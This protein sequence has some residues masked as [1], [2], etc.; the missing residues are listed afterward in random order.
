MCCWSCFFCISLGAALDG[1]ALDHHLNYV[2]NEAVIALGGRV[3]RLFQIGLNPK[4]QHGG[5]ACAYVFISTTFVLSLY[6]KVLQR[7]KTFELIK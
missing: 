6:F 5:I 4:G 7:L 2:G 3:Q 1:L